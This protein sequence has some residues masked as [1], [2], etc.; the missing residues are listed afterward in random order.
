MPLSLENRLRN[1]RAGR[2]TPSAGAPPPLMADLLGGLAVED[3]DGAYYLIRRT[4]PGSI[5]LPPPQPEGLRRNLRLLY[6]VGP[7]TEERL[8]ALGVDTLDQLADHARWSA[9]AGEILQAIALK[10][11]RHLQRKGARDKDLLSFFTPEDLV[12]LDIE[13]TG[14]YSVLPLFLVGLLYLA[15]GKLH[16]VQFLARHFGEERP[17]LAAVAAHLP[18]FKMIVSY[19]GRA[20]DLPY[21]SG[22]FMA[23]KL[24]CRLDHIHLDLLRH[25]RRKYRGLLPDCRLSTV[26]AVA[27]ACGGRADDVPGYMIP[28]L[29]HKFVRTQDQAIIRGIVEHNA[30]DL[31]ALAGLI[32]LVE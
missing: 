29:Y 20:F 8:R 25:A 10:D 15:E 3:G 19:N 11:V 7:R 30:Q 28:E 27:L 6:G 31:L 22:R 14:L 4:Y 21:L 2:Q 9:Q 17:L 12:F 1:F 23:H 18:R 26:E 13:T 24:A 16:L 5:E 32:R